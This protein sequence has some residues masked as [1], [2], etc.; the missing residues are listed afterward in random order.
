MSVPLIDIVKNIYSNSASR[1]M[2]VNEL[3]L[4]VSRLYSNEY[5]DLEVAKKKISSCL[6]GNVKSRNP[7]FRRV[8]NKNKDSYKKGFYALKVFRTQK[9]NVQKHRSEM[10]K[11][12]TGRGGEFAVIS[13]LLFFGHNATLLPVDTGIDVISSKDDNYYHIQVKTRIWDE[14]ADNIS[15]SIKKSAFETNR[16]SNDYYIFVIRKVVSNK[17]INDFIVL[18]S[19]QLESHYIKTLKNKTSF[20]VRFDFVKDK[21]LM[22]NTNVTHFLNNFE[23][24]Q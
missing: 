16:K 13:E 20:S 6:A 12:Q 21:I 9:I 24:I 11:Q 17:W 15:Y 1:E 5:K 22:D 4:E 10:P 7:V 18:H 23:R 3:A 14:K 2:H 19:S 8:K